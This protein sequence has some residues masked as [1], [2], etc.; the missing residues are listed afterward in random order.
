MYNVSER[1]SAN[2]AKTVT[3]TAVAGTITM[4]D[5]S[6]LEIS[7]SNIKE[8][9]LSV[10]SKINSSGEFRAGGVCADE[11]SISLLNYGSGAQSLDGAQ[12]ELTF[13][14]YTDSGFTDYDS[15]PLG[16]FIADGSTI[17]RQSDTV[18]FKAYDML[19]LF[20]RG[21]QEMTD[22]LYNLVSAACD[23]CGV[24]FGMTQ[25]QFEALP[26]G[27]LTVSVDTARIQTQ[28]D[29]LMYAG[30]LTNSFAKASRDGELVFIQLTCSQDDKGMVVPVRELQGNIRFST[31]FSDS[32]AR[33]T[34]FIMNRNG[35][36]LKNRGRITTSNSDC[37]T[38]EWAENPL[39]ADLS[40]SEVRDVLTT[41]VS[42]IYRCINR[43][44]KAE[45]GGD[46]ALDIGDYV[47]LRGGQI[48]T[49]RGYGTGMITSQTWKYRG[50]HT[51]QCNMPSTIAASSSEAAAALSDDEDDD[52]GTERVQPKSQTEKRIDALEQKVAENSSGETAKKLTDFRGTNSSYVRWVAGNLEFYDENGNKLGYI[53]MNTG[54]QAAYSLNGSKILVNFSDNGAV[55][56]TTAAGTKLELGESSEMTALTLTPRSGYGKMLTIRTT[57]QDNDGLYPPFIKFGDRTLSFRE[58]GL[59]YNG[60]KL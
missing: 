54:L 8:G 9:S 57:A 59:Y 22:T 30:V 37:L 18:S 29:L 21:T 7:D 58:D 39:L 16:R 28:R 26:N 32:T 19:V 35:V 45:F 3:F 42:E 24:P 23:S 10:N 36:R 20:D 43:A 14:L 2:I 47:R 1:Y 31:E 17:K 46:P 53:S 49:K 60:T 11:L 41:A 55:S 4:T 38:L 6:V 52:S 56:I 48:D 25:A 27:T 40:D 34:S 50:S 51:I 13:R 5:G 15:V 44:Y 12:V 33:V